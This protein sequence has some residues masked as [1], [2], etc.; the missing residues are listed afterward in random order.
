MKATM[1]EQYLRDEGYS[2]IRTYHYHH[3]TMVLASKRIAYNYRMSICIKQED[4]NEACFVNACLLKSVAMSS[5]IEDFARECLASS[6]K[7][8]ISTIRRM[9]EEFKENL[10]GK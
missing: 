1:T 4:Y 3:K 6:K 7:E 2:A 9:E 10:G 8:F 5:I